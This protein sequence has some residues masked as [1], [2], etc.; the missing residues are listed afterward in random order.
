MSERF[1]PDWVSAPGD[2][3]RRILDDRRVSAADFAREMGLDEETA[4]RLLD[5][6]EPITSTVA[7]RLSEVL[8]S[9]PGFWLR[10]E[11]TYRDGLARGLSRV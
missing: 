3:M 2:T 4:L 8:G 6:S 5:G 1:D 10:R 9:N 11:Q 7:A